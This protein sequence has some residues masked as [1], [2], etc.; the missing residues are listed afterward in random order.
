MVF[1]RLLYLSVFEVSRSELK[2]HASST[3]NDAVALISII[4]L[5]YGQWAYVW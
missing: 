2:I 4:S 5:K 1:A 3:R